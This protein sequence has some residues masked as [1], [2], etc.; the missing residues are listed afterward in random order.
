MPLPA[1]LVLRN[2]TLAVAPDELAELLSL[3]QQWSYVQGGLGSQLNPD[4][5]VWVQQA[6]QDVQVIIGM[7]VV[8]MADWAG[9]SSGFSMCRGFGLPPFATLACA[10]VSGRAVLWAPGGRAHT[11]I[12]MR[13]W[14]RLHAK[15]FERGGGGSG[16]LQH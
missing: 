3:T 9:Q 13:C 16:R 11:Y 10:R 1:A 2:A 4:M 5:A 12:N 8:G 7:G 15:G 6:I 14:Q